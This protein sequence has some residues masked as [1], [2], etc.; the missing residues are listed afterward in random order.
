IDL[1]TQTRENAC[2]L[3][4]TP[5]AMCAHHAKRPARATTPRD[6]PQRRSA[7]R[8]SAER[9]PRPRRR[10]PRARLVDPEARRSR[11]RRAAVDERDRPAPRPAVV[12]RARR[13][14]RRRAPLRRAHARTCA[15]RARHPATGAAM[16]PLRSGRWIGI[17]VGFG[18]VGRGGNLV[19]AL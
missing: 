19:V 8:R 11:P 7:L 14:T 15:R 12:R 5:L 13:G 2:A 9:S 16:T 18:V 17:A 10:D 6:P 3:L 4:G 1:R